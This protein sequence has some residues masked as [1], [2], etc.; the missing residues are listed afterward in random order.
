MFER[1]GHPVRKLKRVRIGSVSLGN[2]PSGQ[3]RS[4]TP[5]EIA[6]LRGKGRVREQGTE[7][8]RNDR[9]RGKSH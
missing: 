8:S 1:V 3:Y 7:V 5:A 4:L 9:N 6:S 2:L